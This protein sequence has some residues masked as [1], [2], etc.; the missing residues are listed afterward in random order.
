MENHKKIEKFLSSRNL[1]PST[2]QMYRGLLV[3]FTR[4]LDSEK[5]T[6]KWPENKVYP[7]DFCQISKLFSKEPDVLKLL[8]KAPLNIRDYKFSETFRCPDCRKYPNI[9]KDRRD[10]I[11]PSTK[12]E[13]IVMRCAT[14]DIVLHNSVSW[15]EF[16]TCKCGFKYSAIN[17]RCV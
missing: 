11:S 7:P 15:W 6:H 12:P 5:V 2:K 13:D 10:W 4:W 9:H 1:S 14:E 16:W 8:E 17:G 3:S